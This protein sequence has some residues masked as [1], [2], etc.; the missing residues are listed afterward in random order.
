MRTVDARLDAI[1]RTSQHLVSEQQRLARRIDAAA[2]SSAPTQT[3]APPVVDGGVC[4]LCGVYLPTSEELLLHAQ[5]CLDRRGN[6][7]NT[8]VNTTQASS[9]QSGNSSGGLFARFRGG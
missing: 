6:G 1:E 3:A 7:A 4:P 5:Q 9:Q 8:A 2:T